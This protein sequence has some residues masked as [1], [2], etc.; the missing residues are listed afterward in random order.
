MS[1]RGA[2]AVPDTLR[3]ATSTAIA[4]PLAA[5]NADAPPHRGLQRAAPILDGSTCRGW[6]FRTRTMRVALCPA[7]STARFRGA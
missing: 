4:V 2:H 1:R 6:Y 7:T 3:G 5:E